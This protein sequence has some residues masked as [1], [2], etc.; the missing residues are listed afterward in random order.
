MNKM[1]ESWHEWQ[2]R[3]RIDVSI[4]IVNW[5]TKGHLIK[6]LRSIYGTTKNLDYEIYV[7][8]NG[9]SDGSPEVVMKQFPQVCLIRNN[10]NL[11][12]ARANNIAISKSSG[13]YICLINSDILVL[14]RCIKNLLTFMDSHPRVGLVSPRILNPD[15]TLQP[16]WRRFPT[17]WRSLLRTF[18]VDRLFP[19]SPLFLGKSENYWTDKPVR[20][21]D[22]LIGCFWIIRRQAIAQVGLMDED[23][24]IY[25]EDYDW[26]KRFHE[27][28]WDL[29]YH[30]GAEAIHYGSLS[31]NNAPVML[32]IEMN[33]AQLLYRKKH[34][35]NI[36]KRCHIIIIFLQQVIRIVSYGILYTAMEAKR[37]DISFKIKRSAACLSWLTKS[38]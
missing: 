13:R 34:H 25:G 24:F 36:S 19:T 26:C 3:E 20:N 5:N 7:V 8:D 2:N 29:V 27:A 6:C 16:N 23:F 38:F 33:K 14:N 15:R 11:G 12:F 21:V 32:Y 35:G 30:P 17:L 9:S 1:I 18:A 31:F 10:N 22:V 28:D 37:K 4:I